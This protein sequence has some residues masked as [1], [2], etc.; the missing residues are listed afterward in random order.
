MPLPRTMARFNKIVTNRVTTP[1]AQLLPGT[2]VVEHRGRRSGRVF[3]TP[4]LLFGVGDDLRIALTYGADTDWVRNVCAAGEAVVHTR[5][6]AIPVRDPRLGTDRQA[7]WAPLPVRVALQ[8]IGAHGYL[9][10]TPKAHR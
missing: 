7:S 9:D 2:A 8:A 6:R 4:V 5:G 1:F 10:C 3:R